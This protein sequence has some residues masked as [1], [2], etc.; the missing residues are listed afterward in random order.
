MKI[1]GD[2]I[3][4]EDMVRAIRTYR[5]EVVINGWGG[6]HTGHGQHQASGMLTPQGRGGS[7]RSERV[8]RADCGRA[9]PW[10]V[11]LELRLGQH[12]AGRN[13]QADSARRPRRDSMP[14]MDVSPLWGESYIAMGADGRAFHRSQGTPALFR[15]RVS[16]AGLYGG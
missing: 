14:V 5:P 10:K 9:R 16:P 1:W 13:E 4:L 8:S 7:R 2:E 11:T 6:V 15:Q 12:Y 3:P